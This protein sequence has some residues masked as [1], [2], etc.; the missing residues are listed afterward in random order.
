MKT[1]VIVLVSAFV[2]LSVG[3]VRADKRLEMWSLATNDSPVQLKAGS[4]RADEDTAETSLVLVNA[5]DRPIAV[6][7]IT[8]EGYGAFEDRLE[9]RTTTLSFDKPLK[10]TKEKT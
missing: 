3:S 2:A 6:T 9:T 4:V 1:R 8:W 5:K 10:A 7:E